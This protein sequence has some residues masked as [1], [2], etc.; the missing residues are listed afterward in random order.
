[1]NLSG[2]L[3]YCFQFYFGR[4][5]GTVYEKRRAVLGSSEQDSPPFH[6][7]LLFFF[8]EFYFDVLSLGHQT[9][10]KRIDTCTGWYSS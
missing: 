4:E 9:S 6:L 1:M 3:Y 7:A 10:Y 5:A 8:F 2:V